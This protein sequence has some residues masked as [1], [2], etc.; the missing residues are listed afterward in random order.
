MGTAGRTFDLRIVT[1][2]GPEYTFTSINKEEHE[3]TEA[4]LKDKKVKI[5]NEMVPDADLLMAVAGVDDEDDDD[6][7]DEDMRSVDGSGDDVPRVRKGANDEDSEEGETKVPFDVL[8]RML[9]TIA[10]DEDFQASE[11]D[12]DSPSD[13]DSSDGGG[14]TASDASGDCELANAAKSMAKAQVKT[15]TKA[16]TKEA[17]NDRSSPK[18]ESAPRRLRNQVAEMHLGKRNQQ[19]R[20]R[21]Y[22]MKRKTSKAGAKAKVKE[23]TS[24]TTNLLQYGERP[25]GDHIDDSHGLSYRLRIVST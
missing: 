17:V 14:D 8:D 6:D 19:R 9:T 18:E 11:S 20:Q 2:S 12:A 10:L 1:K 13:S 15:K 4:Y 21:A 23:P 25:A 24:T 22:Q 7:D 5:K 3:S 16:K